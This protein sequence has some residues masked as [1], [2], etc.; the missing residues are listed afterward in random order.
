MHVPLAGIVDREAERERNRRELD[1]I[2][3]QHE[4]VMAKL[5]NAAFREKADNLGAE[6][7]YMGPEQLAAYTKEELDRWGKVVKAAN[8]KA[9]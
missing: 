7:L 4:G 2:R 5:S 3:K 1:K 9:E 8:I 6:A